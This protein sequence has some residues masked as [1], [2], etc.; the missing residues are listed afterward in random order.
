MTELDIEMA[1]LDI[2]R[3]ADSLLQAAEDKRARGYVEANR[4]WLLDEVHRLSEILVKVEAN[5]RHVARRRSADQVRGA[6]RS[7]SP[8]RPLTR[9]AIVERHAG[10]E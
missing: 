2:K 4:T 9:S 5:S 7:R 1:L 8:S 6:A 3:A 10:A